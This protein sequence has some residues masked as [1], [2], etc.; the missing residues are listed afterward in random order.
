MAD[1]DVATNELSDVKA[2]T[3]IRTTFSFVS[4]ACYIHTLRI[5]YS[6]AQKCED[7]ALA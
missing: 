2:L 4:L 3:F 6:V 1:Q 7:S 5:S